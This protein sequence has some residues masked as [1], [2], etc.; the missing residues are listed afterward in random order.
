MNRFATL[1]CALVLAAA[2]VSSAWAQGQQPMRIVSGFPPGGAVDALARIFAERFT[3]ALGR[4]VVVDT[5]AGASGQIAALAVKAAP[6]DG[7]TILVAPDSFAVLYPHT[8]AKP[9]YDPLVEFVPVAHVGGYPLAFAVGA[10]VPAKDVKEYIT[11]AKSNPRNASFGTPGAGSN[12]HFL[13]VLIGQTLGLPM[14]HIGYKGVGP[15]INDAVG[16]QVPA[17]IMPLGTVLAQ[18]NAGKL[19]VL[20]HSGSRRSDAAPSIAT[21]RELGYPVE[22]NGWFGLFAPAK[23]PAAVTARL[24]DIVIQ[25]IRNEAVRAKLRSLD[26]ETREMTQAELVAHLKAEYDRWAPVVKASGFT[27]DQ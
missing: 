6:P 5:R 10:G 21:F 4:T 25:S 13:G 23:T 26:L 20:A 22:V 12:A 11:W 15:A 16:G 7:N 3:E 1:G 17:V 8:V 19:R 24:N 14:V 2:Q 18:A 27:S 9:A